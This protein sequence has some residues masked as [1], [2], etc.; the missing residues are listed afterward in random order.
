MTDNNLVRFPGFI[1]LDDRKTILKDGR[2]YKGTKEMIAN[3]SR[4]ELRQTYEWQIKRNL[5]LRGITN[6]TP[7]DRHAAI[8][9]DHRA[10]WL[11]DALYQKHGG[12]MS[13]GSAA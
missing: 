1:L 6:P 13:G 2:R 7:Q 9:L 12:A 11:R 4:H 8:V 3:L 10:K 5:A